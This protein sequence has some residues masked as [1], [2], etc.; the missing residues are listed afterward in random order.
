MRQRQQVVGNIVV[1]GILLRIAHCKLGW[2]NHPPT[3]PEGKALAGS[4]QRGCQRELWRGQG[5]LQ[6]G[7]GSG[8]RRN[9]YGGSGGGQLAEQLLAASCWIWSI[10]ESKGGAA[11]CSG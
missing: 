1:C 4:W 11:S 8:S 5:G 9:C 6:A 10:A 7:A 2:P 3:H